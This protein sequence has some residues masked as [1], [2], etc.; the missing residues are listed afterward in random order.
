MGTTATPR[1]AERVLHIDLHPACAGFVGHVERE[2]ERNPHLA[3]LQGE[4][5]GPLQVFRIA[6]RDDD[7]SPPLEQDVAGDPLVLRRRDERIGSWGVE[8]LD[9]RSA[10]YGGP[11]DPLDRRAGVVRHGDVTP[12]QTPE[13]GALADVRVCPTRTTPRLGPRLG[14]GARCRPASP[15]S[16]IRSHNDHAGAA[17]TGSQQAPLVAKRVSTRSV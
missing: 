5:D 3:Q 4:P 16:P 14:I 11:L 1:R 7:A 9:R 15:R 2:N 13:Q 12:G 6:D 17:S 10:D 8:D